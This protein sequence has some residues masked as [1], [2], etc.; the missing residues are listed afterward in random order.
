MKRGKVDYNQIQHIP[1]LTWAMIE[2][3]LFREMVLNYRKPRFIVY[4][5]SSSLWKYACWV[6]QE[7]D[8]KGE[9]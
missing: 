6:Q 1:K 8:E 5:T 2:R 9:S 7:I 4:N 3:K